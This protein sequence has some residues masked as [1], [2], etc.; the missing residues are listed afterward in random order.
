M[1][2]YLHTNKVS[3][4]LEDRRG[5]FHIILSWKDKTAKRTRRYISTGLKVKGNKRR[6]EEML[7]EACR[8]QEE[9]L[10]SIPT[11]PETERLLF[12]D[13]MEQWLEAIRT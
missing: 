11:F 10:R 7:K 1:E 6:A 2:N 8:K 9:E 13:F 12:A 3:G 5:I 4:H